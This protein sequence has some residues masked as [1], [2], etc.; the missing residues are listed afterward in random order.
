MT[1]LPRGTGGKRGCAGRDG[2]DDRPRF[3]RARPLLSFTDA[4]TGSLGV[5]LGAGAASGYCG[6]TSRKPAGP[7]STWATAPSR[8]TCW[9]DVLKDRDL[10]VCNRRFDFTHTH[11][12]FF[13]DFWS[14]WWVSSFCGGCAEGLTSLSHGTTIHGVSHRLE[15]SLQGHRRHL[16]PPCREELRWSGGWDGFWFPANHR[17]Q[18]LYLLTSIVSRCMNSFNEPK[19]LILICPGQR[20]LQ[21]KVSTDRNGEPSEPQSFAAPAMD[22]G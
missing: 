2:T 15:I 21:G 17:R 22:G 10:Q 5:P 7:E 4:N 1:R 20:A 13:G 6:D 14:P 19:R 12:G 3:T 9:T 8:N 11:M 18:Y 16:Q